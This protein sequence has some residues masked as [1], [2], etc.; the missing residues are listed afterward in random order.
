MTLTCYIVDDEY[1]SIEIIKSFIERT[2]DVELLGSSVDP[3]SALNT[4][5]ISKPPSVIFMDVDMPDLTG[6]EFAGMVS[7][8]SQ[9]IFITAYPE[10]A[11]EAFEKDAIDYILKPLNYERFIKSINKVRRKLC[12]V[13]PQNTA[14]HEF[15]FVS[16]ETKGKMVKIF[17]D[18]IIFFESV[19]NYIKIHTANGTYLV[20][21]MLSEVEDK[22]L[23]ERFS[24]IHKSF[25]INNSKIRT[26]DGAFIGLEDKANTILPLGRSFKADFMQQMNTRI[27][28]SKRKAP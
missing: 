14:D 10:Y 15:F 21:L 22:L 5:S 16:H 8:Y 20:Y 6:M 24:R 4:I 2:K 3:V 12:D 23:K 25:I 19:D 11:I 7:Y 13:T 18:D 9:V 17:L 27:W 26:I 1:H 28:K